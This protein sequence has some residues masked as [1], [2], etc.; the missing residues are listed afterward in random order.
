MTAKLQDVWV[1]YQAAVR[2]ARAA[3]KAARVAHRRW[4]RAGAK[5]VGPEWDALLDQAYQRAIDRR[6]RALRRLNAA[7]L[8]ETK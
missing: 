6:G 1:A 5:M 2:E 8:R 3:G 7:I 4:A